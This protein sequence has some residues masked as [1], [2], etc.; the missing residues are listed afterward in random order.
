MAKSENDV[1]FLS[2]SLFISLSTPPL[3]PIALLRS[4]E[5][6][7]HNAMAGP[8]TRARG[9]WAVDRATSLSEVWAIVAKHLALVGAWRLMLV[10][11][12]GGA[13]GVLGL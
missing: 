8:T 3:H 2:V 9:Y 13:Q 12:A 7:N 5:G 6:H 11:R 10:C 4:R 1:T